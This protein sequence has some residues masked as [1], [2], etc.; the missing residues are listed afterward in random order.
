MTWSQFY[1]EVWWDQQQMP[2]I[3]IE[4]YHLS[5]M[6]KNNLDYSMISQGFLGQIVI[7]IINQ[8]RLIMICQTELGLR[9]ITQTSILVVETGLRCTA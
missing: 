2:V 5:Q 1:I 9:Q 8:E 6:Y 7:I 3:G 4:E